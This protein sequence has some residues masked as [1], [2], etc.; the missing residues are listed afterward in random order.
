MGSYLLVETRD[1]FDSADVG[2]FY[3][4]AEGLAEHGDEVSV[5]LVQNG[6]LACRRASTSGDTVARLASRVNVLAD[7][8]SLR[9]RGIGGDELAEGVTPAEIDALV[10]LVVE[11][12]RRVI[13]H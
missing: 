7:Q 3:E 13:W 5:F 8:F 10:D 12:G 9:E 11:D 4:L 2:Q 6:V 1:P